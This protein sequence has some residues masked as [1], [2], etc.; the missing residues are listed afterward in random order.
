MLNLDSLVVSKEMADETPVAILKGCNPAD[1]RELDTL[2]FKGINDGYSLMGQ[3]HSYI[4]V[5]RLYQ[6]KGEAEYT[7][8]YYGLRKRDLSIREFKSFPVDVH[9]LSARPFFAVNDTTFI[10]NENR[11]DE[12]THEIKATVFHKLVFDSW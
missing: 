4:I 7:A 11:F 9:G 12:S 6:K 3:S 5:G 1:I 10:I 8:E 2:L